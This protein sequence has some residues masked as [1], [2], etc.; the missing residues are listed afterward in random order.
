MSLDSATRSRIEA[1]LADHRVLLFMKGE[2]NAPQCGFSAKAIGALRATGT[3]FGHVDVLQDPEI[4]EGIKVFSD[5]PTI[6]QLYID[7][8][9]VG[10]SDI[11]EQM[12]NSGELFSALGLAPPDRTPPQIEITEAAAQVIRESLGSAGEGYALQIAIDPGYQSRMQLAPVDANA[13]AVTSSGIRTQFDLASA[14]RAKGLRI[15]WVDDERG[16]GLVIDNPNAPAPVRTI[17]VSEAANGAWKIVDV[18]PSEERALAAINVPFL[19]LDE[20][21]ATVETLPKDTA[22]AFLCHSGGRSQQA[23]EYFRG[24]GF[25][26]VANI[27]GGIAAWADEV[28]GN[29]SKY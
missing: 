26:N 12:L 2:P 9:L 6:P 5:W 10:G 1:L 4:R 23:A 28:D 11:I 14:G 3:D 27:A 18:R 29:V 24:L 16:R 17:S 21:T 8:E 13:I 15:D 19:T 20:G 25:S 7:G 22:L